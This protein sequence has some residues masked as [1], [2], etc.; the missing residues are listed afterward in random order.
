M[1]A[2]VAINEATVLASDEPPSCTVHNPHGVSPVLL[3]ADHASNRVPRSLNQL[4]L[5]Q[6][7]LDQHVG[8]DIGTDIVALEMSSLFDAT[9]VKANY[10]RLVIDLNRSLDDVTVMTEVSDEVSVPGNLDLDPAQRAARVHELYLPY[11]QS[12][13]ARLHVI[14]NR[15]VIP[16]LIAIHSFTPQMNGDQRPWHVGVL[17]DKDPR[18]PI[19]LMQALEDH[20]ARLVVGDNQPYSGKHPADYTIDHHAEAAG[21]PHVSIEIRQDLI[22]SPDR[23]R[24]WARILCDCLRPI[25]ADPEL[26]RIWQQ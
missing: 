4:G 26:Y 11:R 24:L 19:P 17:W 12:I 21:L 15:G 18:I 7:L 23:A 8:W 3:V 2:K 14:R 1:D 6:K 20:P 13:E 22:D 25:L 5:D 10:S 16:A 9:L